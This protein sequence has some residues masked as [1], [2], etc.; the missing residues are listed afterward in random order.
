M[1]RST[2]S[3][4]KLSHADLVGMLDAAMGQMEAVRQ[5][6]AI[7]AAPETVADLD[8]SGERTLDDLGPDFEDSTGWDE[9]YDSLSFADRVA[10]IAE[11]YE[12]AGRLSEADVMIATGA[13]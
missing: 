9:E 3:L 11:G 10:E 6:L 7:M 13:Y 4:R 1:V 2:A 5:A 12:E 8:W